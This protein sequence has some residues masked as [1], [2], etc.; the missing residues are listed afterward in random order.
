MKHARLDLARRAE[1][2]PALD[3]TIAVFGPIALERLSGLNTGD[4]RCVS[5]MFTVNKALKSADISVTRAI[6]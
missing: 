1:L 5:D 2:L 3:G 4:L 6:E